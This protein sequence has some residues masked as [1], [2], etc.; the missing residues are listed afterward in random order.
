MVNVS[1]RRA[2]TARRLILL[3]TMA[4]LGI[5]AVVVGGAF[6]P[7]FS[8]AQAAERPEGNSPFPPNSRMEQFFRR[9]ASPDSGRDNWWQQDWPFPRN[10][11]IEQ[12]FRGFGN[13]DAGRDT[14]G[15]MGVQI[16][17]VTA[18]I[19]DSLGMKTSDG[20]LVVEPQADSPAAKA[21][22]MSGDVITAVNGTAVKICQP[23]SK[24]V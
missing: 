17:P 5:A 12:F 9:F 16:Q 24:S 22:I 14:R 7:A 18:E 19:A 20:A 23:C 11:Q 15:W 8:N 3:A 4:N 21:G 2:V 10:S 1:R 6:V 13:P